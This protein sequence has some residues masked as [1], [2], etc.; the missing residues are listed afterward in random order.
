MIIPLRLGASQS[1]LGRPVALVT[2]ASC[3]ISWPAGRVARVP[4]VSSNWRAKS[5]SFNWRAKFQIAKAPK[6]QRAP[7]LWLPGIL[8]LLLLLFGAEAKA[9]RDD[10][11]GLAC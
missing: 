8:V 6:Q 5:A 11:C 7:L 2:G 3:P 10:G 1:P 9:N 4:G